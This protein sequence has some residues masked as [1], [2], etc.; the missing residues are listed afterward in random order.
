M[1]WYKKIKGSRYKYEVTKK[2]VFK[3][4][5]RPGL[6]IQF[7]PTSSL[8]SLDPKGILTISP[9]YRWDGAD[10]F[11]DVKEVMRASLAH[12]ALYQL[13]RQKL[14]KKKWRKSSDRL[15][16]RLCIEDGLDKLVAEI[17][18]LALRLVGQVR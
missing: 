2:R 10:F 6:K 3:T 16:R 17:C 9:G 13:I 8:I 4:K 7:P 11:P 15:F 12:D 18:Y 5:I 14:L 1:K